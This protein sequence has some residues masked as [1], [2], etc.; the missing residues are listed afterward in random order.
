VPNFNLPEALHEHSISEFQTR[1]NSEN[2][3]EQLMRRPD[4]ESVLLEALEFSVD[5]MLSRQVHSHSLASP[6]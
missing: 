1:P 5:D 3:S 6:L 4:L 2:Y